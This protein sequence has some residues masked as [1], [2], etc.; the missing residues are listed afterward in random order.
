MEQNHGRQLLQSPPFFS[1][2]L[3]LA[4]SSC[5]VVVP[6]FPPTAPHH[7]PFPHDDVFPQSPLSC[8][9]PFAPPLVTEPHALLI[10]AVFC[11]DRGSQRAH[12]TLVALSFIL[13]PGTIQIT[14]LLTS[15]VTPADHPTTATWGSRDEHEA[16]NFTLL[17]NENKRPCSTPTVPSALCP[18]RLRRPV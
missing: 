5:T 12:R 13:C 1:L 11:S 7:C 14:Q 8:T 17:S 2:K 3:S 15:E 6:P 16:G 4:G 9:K 18:C 10:S